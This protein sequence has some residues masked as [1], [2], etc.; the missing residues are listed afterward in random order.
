MF[1]PELMKRASAAL[2]AAATADEGGEAA[3]ARVGAPMRGWQWKALQKD[4]EQARRAWMPRVVRSESTPLTELLASPAKQSLIGAGVGGLA[5]GGL[6]VAAGQ[7]LPGV[8]DQLRAA[9]AAGGLGLGAVLGA[10]SA[11]GRRRRS[12]DRVIDALRRTPPGAT[13]RDYEALQRA[14]AARPA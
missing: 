14:D 7:F 9:L 13:L 6:G 2:D 4:V 3:P 5:G 8:P 11:Y 12:N 10:S 1:D